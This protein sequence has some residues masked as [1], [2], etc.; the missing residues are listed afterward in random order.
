MITYALRWRVG[1]EEVERGYR[2][3]LSKQRF[4]KRGH[5][6]NAQSTHCALGHYHPS[7]LESNYCMQLQ[8][9]VK[10]GEIKGFEYG[11]KYELRINGK[12]IGC[13]KPD[14]SVTNNDGTL[15]V[16]E[17]KGVSTPDW[18]LRKNLFEALYPNVPYVVIR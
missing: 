10:A 15:A 1:Y 6:Y 11:K 2:A 12:L 8:M 14:F 7:K 3:L 17:T 4:I 9:L 5:K 13:H 16:H 18:V